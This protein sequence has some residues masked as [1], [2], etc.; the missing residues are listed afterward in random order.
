MKQIA[1]AGAGLVGALLASTLA[2]RG[3]RVEVFERRSD[4]RRHEGSAG[5]SI[6]LA[7]SERGWQALRDIGLEEKVRR[8]AIPM[9]G[10]M[11]HTLDGRQVLIPYDV[12]GRA[13]ASV[14]RKEL[15]RIL[16]D[17]AEAEGSTF[18]FN[19]ECVSADAETGKTVVGDGSGGRKEIGPDLLFG[20]DGAFSAVRLSMQRSDRFNYSQEYLRHGYKELSIPPAEGGGWRMEKNALHIW[21][22]RQYMLIALPNFDGSF[23]CTLFLP[24]EGPAAFEHLRSPEDVATFF[25]ESFPDAVPL[26][27]TLL[28]DFFEN[29]TSS[30]CTVR[31]S[32]WTFQGRVALIGDAAHAIVPFYGQG[33]NAGFEDCTILASLIDRGGEITAILGEYEKLR[34]PN[35]DAIADLALK[36]FVEMRDRSADPRFW[37]RKKLER[38]IHELYPDRYTPVYSLVSFSGMPYREILDEDR[39]QDEMFDALMG[40]VG[41]DG[42]EES[43]DVV[44]AIHRMMGD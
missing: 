11:I 6:N 10:R 22:R 40:V 23:T 2:R 24:F 25:R 27:P 29:P 17:G 26:M 34:K 16:L 32:P 35:G 39:R 42:N 33:M 30:L 43:L 18:H 15:N 8:I 20:A 41:N 44:A 3:F 5:R 7:V 19:A 1:I 38:K 13:I 21:P 31:C 14:S 37:W 9:K 12:R 4:L 36:N 28:T